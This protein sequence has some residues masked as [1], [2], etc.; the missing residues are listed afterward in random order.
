MKLIYLLVYLTIILSNLILYLK[1]RDRSRIIFVLFFF[2]L[3]LIVFDVYVCVA[4]VCVCLISFHLSFLT[5]QGHASVTFPQCAPITTISH[6]PT[7][8]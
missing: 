7:K 6:F 8:I 5:P 4:V 3:C 2:L 1:L